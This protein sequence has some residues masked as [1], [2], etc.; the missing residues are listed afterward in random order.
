MALSGVRFVLLSVILLT[1]LR[2]Q[3]LTT[4]IQTTTLSLAGVSGSTPMNIAWHPGFEQYYGGRG[5]STSYG[6]IVWNASGGVVQNLSP[7]NTDLQRFFYKP[8]TGQPPD[9]ADAHITYPPR[10]QA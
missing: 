5:G 8:N 10:Q 2:A 9:I 3:F 4:G 7:I 1:S 6:G